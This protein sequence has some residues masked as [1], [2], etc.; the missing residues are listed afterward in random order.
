MI[1]IAYNLKK[2]A[3]SAKLAIPGVM[4]TPDN[5]TP[6]DFAAQAM[7]ARTPEQ[8]AFMQPEN[9][10]ARRTD[11]LALDEPDADSRARKWV[12]GGLG[13]TG[14]NPSVIHEYLTRK[15]PFSAKV[16]DSLD[17]ARGA[18]SELFKS[19][20]EPFSG[21]AYHWSDGR[22]GSDYPEDSYFIDAARRLSNKL[23]GHPVPLKYKSENDPTLN[24]L[25][26]RSGWFLGGAA[27]VPAAIA[28]RYGGPKAK[29]LLSITPRTRD[30][31][32]AEKVFAGA[33]QVAG[34]TT[35][36]VLAHTVEN[37]LE[38]TIPPVDTVQKNKETSIKV[39]KA[40]GY[41]APKA[42]QL[43]EKI[44]WGALNALVM[45]YVNNPYY[46]I[47]RQGGTNP[48][49]QGFTGMIGSP[50]PQELNVPNATQV[51]RL[52]LSSPFSLATQGLTSAAANVATSTPG[53]VAESYR[54]TKDNVMD[55][56]YLTDL[57][58]MKERNKVIEQSRVIRALKE[59][60]GDDWKTILEMQSG[61]QP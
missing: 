35:V 42:E 49:D 38:K 17:L 46:Y 20:A 59:Y 57:N 43:A 9:I 6:E 27:A 37:A 61:Q 50:L 54:Q 28:A 47:Y 22:V 29:R 33:K 1:K 58:K 15:H 8:T 14:A 25:L 31:S 51:S 12:A 53:R 55:S 11:R 32:K 44:S 19:F 48:I 45:E 52:I 24:N 13:S 34:A 21:A 23:P 39:L 30:L 40:L 36:P 26:G 18:G 5:M 41:A 10:Q 3:N 16:V 7:G 60:F 56:T 2:L 4:K